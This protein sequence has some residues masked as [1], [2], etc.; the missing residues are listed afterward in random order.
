MKTKKNLGKRALSILLTLLMVIS[1]VPMSTL[2]ASA[3]TTD[4][5]L[6]LDT[7]DLTLVP[8]ETYTLETSVRES[9]ECAYGFTWESSNPSV[10]QVDE[11]GNVTAVSKGKATITVKGESTDQ[12]NYG[13]MYRATCDVLVGDGLK[14]TIDNGKT[15]SIMDTDGDGYYEIDS[16]DKLYA[17]AAIVNGGNNSINAELTADIV[18]NENVL[19]ADGTL[20]ENGNFR[21][22]T[23]IGNI[24]FYYSGTFD[25]QNYGVSGLYFNDNTKGAVGLFGLIS[26]TVKNTNVVN[27]YFYGK[28][29]I[30]GV[31]GSNYGYV[32]NCCNTSTV[33]GIDNVGGVAG[34]NSGYVTNCYNTGKAEGSSSIGGVVGQLKLG[35]VENCYTQVLSS[36]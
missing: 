24:D 3:G 29:Y 18:V 1:L 26:G 9:Y 17:F 23:P 25:G 7:Y 6:Y 28:M 35:T 27:S 34:Y 12:W 36:V 31:V 13:W 8:G 16:A 4:G 10:A 2:T 30:G 20:N 15:V 22:W 14:A 5:Y 32:T 33:K 21:A 19:K 11:Y